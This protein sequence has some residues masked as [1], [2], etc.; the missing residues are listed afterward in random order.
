M[1][2]ILDEQIEVYKALLP[3]LVAKHGPVWALVADRKLVGTFGEFSDAARFAE[4]TF[5]NKT[6]LIRHTSERP[7]TAPFILVE[8]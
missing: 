6:V 1:P 2:D 3:E 7:E 5:G 8:G 4:T